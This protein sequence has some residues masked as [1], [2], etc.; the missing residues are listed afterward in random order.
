MESIRASILKILFFKEA[1]GYKVL[2]TRQLSGKSLVIV[3]EF[4]P[5]II[6]ESVAD[7]HGEFKTH[8]KYGYQFKAYSYTMVH[9]AEELQSIRLFLDTIAP[10]VGLIRSSTIVE[11]FKMDTVSILDFHPERLNE[12]PGIG[13]IS[14]NSLIAAWKENRQKWDSERIIYSV[15]AFL[16]TLGLKERRIKKV[17]S[18]FGGHVFDVE[19]KIKENPYQLIKIEGFGFS[20]VDFIARK[21]GITED[22][23]DRLKAFIVYCVEIVCSSFGHLFFT[24]PEIMT[25]INEFCIQNN[26]KFLGRNITVEDINHT[27]ITLEEQ[28]V[29]DQDK[30]YS[31]KQYKFESNSAMILNQIM[32]TKSDLMFLTKEAVEEFIN[33]FEHENGI[34]L[35]EE[36]KIA[37]YYFAE[38]KVFII[39]GVPGSGKCLGYNTPVIMFDGTTKMVQDIV[40]EDLL[41]GDDSTP[42]RVLSTCTGTDDLYKITPIKG[43]PFIIN[44]PHILSLK[45]N[46]DRRELKKGFIFD[47]P[48]PDY[49]NLPSYMKHYLKLYKVPLTFPYKKV[50]L[51]PYLVGYWLGNGNSTDTGISTP[52]PEVIKHISKIVTPFGL[53]VKKTS[54]DNVDY[55]ITC[56]RNSSYYKNLSDK[57]FPN[58]FMDKLRELN[59]IGNKHIRNTP[60][61]SCGYFGFRWP[62]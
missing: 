62:L 43:D 10:N 12:V 25:V 24:I 59:L 46:K 52:F 48:L 38:K 28:V 23:P 4:G 6:P 37:L 39:T 32:E 20:T 53:S 15:R 54:G 45:A 58:K 35:S 33:K 57:R 42:R 3:G 22:S 49:L 31:K 30:I 61:N 17:L 21:L 50:P 44:K 36:Q 55:D 41:M 19:N 27:L 51:D 34:E 60:Q 5:E 29:I 14:S 2:I 13:E 11:F 9:N 18:Y 1:S 7:F 26:T 16:G 47:I 40:K 56:D 8:Q